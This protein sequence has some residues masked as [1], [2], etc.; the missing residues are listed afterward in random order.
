MIVTYKHAD[1]TVEEVSA[2]DLSAIE[3]AAI[4]SATGEDWNQVELS[5][6]SQSPTAMRAVL[7]VFRK[8]AEPT[9]RFSAFD[10]PGWRRRLTAR[11]DQAEVD[12]FVETL[13]KDHSPDSEEFA[14]M[15]VHLRNLAHESA[16]VDAALSTPEPGPKAAAEADAGTSPESAPTS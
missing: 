11:L 7:W 1:G 13:R 12:D 4:E 5:L 2:D 14:S 10:L 3:S 8:R 9:L 16:D 6:R 15:I